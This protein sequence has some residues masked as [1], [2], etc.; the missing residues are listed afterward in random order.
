MICIA[1]PVFSH[2]AEPWGS[3]QPAAGFKALQNLQQDELTREVMPDLL[4]PKEKG[5]L[6]WAEA[7]ELTVAKLLGEAE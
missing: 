3:S 2:R 1:P 6:L 4:H 7:M 5:Y